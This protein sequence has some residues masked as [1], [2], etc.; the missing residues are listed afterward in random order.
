MSP[1]V[2]R[3]E[4][5]GLLTRS[6]STIDERNI[7]IDLTDQGQQLCVQ[8]SAVSEQISA[9]TGLDLAQQVDLVNQLRTL[10]D[11]L[12]PESDPDD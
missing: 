7:S 11:H 10:E 1:L 9:A 6:R 5:L 2:K 8:I 12:R 4:L 3:L